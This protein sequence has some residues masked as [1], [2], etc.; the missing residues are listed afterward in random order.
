MSEPID[1]LVASPTQ[2]FR[3]SSA[4][5]LTR[6]LEGEIQILLGLRSSTMPIFASYW[7]FPGG[8]SSRKDR[9]AAELLGWDEEDAVQRVTGLREMIEEVGWIPL[10][11]GVLAC[12]PV[13]RRRLLNERSVI[14]ELLASVQGLDGGG[15]QWFGERFTPPIAPLRFH[16]A[17][18]TL[19]VNNDLELP[20]AGD[21]LVE[22]RWVKPGQAMAA[23]RDGEMLI[24]PP[25]VQ[26][27]R[28]FEAAQEQMED[29]DLIFAE[30]SRLSVLHEP[31]RIEFAWPVECIP[32][33]THTLPPATHTNAYLLG[34]PGNG[35]LLIDPTV[36]ND[37][38]EEMLAFCIQRFEETGGS[39]DRVIISHRHSDH[40]P[41]MK[42]LRQVTDATIAASAITLQSLGIEG[43]VLRDGQ[44][45]E[46][47]GSNP[48]VWS[49]LETPGH[50]DGH[51][52]LAG[53]AGVFV[54]DM[55]AGVG[56]ILIPDDGDMDVYLEQ[57]ERLQNLDANLA[58]PSHGPVMANPSQRIAELIAHR[59]QREESILQALK[60]MDG[61][62]HG[63]RDVVYADTPGAHPSLAL[64]QILSHLASLEKSGSVRR[65]QGRWVLCD[66]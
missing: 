52:C 65:D 22:F 26:A 18:F 33:S 54:G 42:R 19:L 57:L 43:E 29:T 16:N 53:T 12:D 31:P 6:V 58:F 23:W 45:I 5:I 39:I 9:A 34:I 47:S 59:R 49:V 62:E 55:M 56:T 14:P 40:R 41:N 37:E 44:I 17:W 30:A 20:E 21:E 60:E 1:G 2:K 25:I 27:L 7:A 11:D 64:T 61:D 36:H 10:K 48:E 50:C 63:L 4:V 3:Q 15:L 66:Q 24:P 32:L 13:L 46:T 35:G 38:A 51:I 8:G 28:A